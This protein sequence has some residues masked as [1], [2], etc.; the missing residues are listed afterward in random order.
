MSKGSG[1]GSRES[2]LNN[3]ISLS[4]SSFLKSFVEVLNVDSYVPVRFTLVHV[5]P[6]GVCAKDD[7]CRV[8]LGDGP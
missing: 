6:P 2:G 3:G 8:G 5:G 1:G 7:L 4:T